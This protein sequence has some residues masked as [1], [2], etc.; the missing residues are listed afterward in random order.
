MRVR[1][2]HSFCAQLLA[3]GARI[4]A[5]GAAHVTGLIQRW[6]EETVASGTTLSQGSSQAG[7]GG[8][9]A[10][11]SSNGG[12]AEEG[13][14][15]M[16]L[17]S[18]VYQPKPWA[19]AVPPAGKKPP[20]WE[21]S[22]GRF[23]TGGESLEKIA[24]TQ[25]NGKS[26]QPSTV[27]GHLLTA[28]TQGRPLALDRLAHQAAAQNCLPP[29]QSEWE[30]LASAEAGSAI[31]VA[32]T[33]KLIMTDLLKTFLPAAEKDFKERSDDEKAVIAL[34]YGRLH[35]FTAMRRIGLQPSFAMGGAAKKPRV[36]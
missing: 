33:E 16:V 23:H 15:V 28:L 36:G 22:H 2:C 9:A 31:D 29:T 26:I 27:L 10:G 25:E 17:P 11:G 34:W 14:A 24:L 1:A 21:A 32:K 20:A 8:A 5:A 4:T 18:G 35:W 30:Q 7:G 6:K 3:L 19:L 12:A 13:D